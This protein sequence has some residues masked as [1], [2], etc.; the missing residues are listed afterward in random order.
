MSYTRREVNSLAKDDGYRLRT[1]WKP[2]MW[3]ILFATLSLFSKEQGITVLAVCF[4]YEV[5]TR[6][7]DAV[8]ELFRTLTT[9][10]KCKS[11]RLSV[12][13]SD[14]LKCCFQR[15]SVLVVAGLALLLIRV[16]VMGAQL[17]VFTKFDNPAAASPTPV[18]QLTQ[19]YLL[20]VNTWLL[21]NPCN[22]CC[23]WTMN[24]I[25]LVKSLF[26]VRMFAILLTYCAFMGLFHRV[27][28]GK[29]SNNGRS[30]IAFCLSLLIFPFLP[31]SNL[32][33]PVG[34]VVAERVLY[35]PSMGFC[36]LVSVGFHRLCKR[37]HK[38]KEEEEERYSW[39]E[40]F[41]K[42]LLHSIWGISL[43]VLLC[44]HAAKTVTRNGEW[45]NEFSLFR[46]GL[47]VVKGNA[48]LFNNVGHAFEQ[49]NRYDEALKY[50]QHAVKV[51]PD[52]I[53]AYIN[54]GRTL[55]QLKLVKEAEEM[56]LKAKSLIPKSKPGKR[57]RRE[58]HQITSTSLST[59]QL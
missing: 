45:R 54:V 58:W 52:D 9:K 49:R 8:A 56:Y 36:L 44:S 55:N 29:T 3:T 51:Q 31:A 5:C 32:F 1:K 11:I 33:F 46:S 28:Y 19:N 4:S 47:R 53:G 2:L 10:R 14:N 17:P 39:G 37:L 43:M 30:V 18:R 23:D 27:F 59:W 34:F 57:T 15:I 42:R 12:I 13:S 6:Q 26:D 50:F 48:K 40:N 16:K 38:W 25:P 41:K 24:S 35:L 22:L 21:L 7:K 20:S